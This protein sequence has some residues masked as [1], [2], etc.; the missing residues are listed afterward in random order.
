M[1]LSFLTLE[2]MKSVSGPWVTTQKKLLESNPKVSGMVD[3]LQAAYN[4]LVIALPGPRVP[5]EVQEKGAEQEDLDN[6]FHDPLARGIDSTLDAC[7]QFAKTEEEATRYTTLHKKILPYG[8]SLTLRSYTEEGG[9]AELLEERLNDEDKKQLGEIPVVKGTLLDR[10][11]E[12]IHYGKLIGKLE[13]EKLAL[14]KAA[15]ENAQ[16]PTRAQSRDA[17]HT[18]IRVV[19]LFLDNLA[20]AKL[21]QKAREELLGPL[22]KEAQVA[23]AR[24]KAKTAQAAKETAASPTTTP[25]KP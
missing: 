4:G 19:K 16:V 11:M 5:K 22:E 6:N 1:N 12:L 17:R 3:D 14:L 20:L 2:Q 10:V 25:A 7:F 15:A 9:A 18:W 8:R 23:V 21:E 24:Q 13:K